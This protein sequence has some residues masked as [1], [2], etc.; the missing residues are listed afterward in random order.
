M[1][2]FVVLNKML[3]D[4]FLFVLLRSNASARRVGVGLEGWNKSAGNRAEPA[5]RTT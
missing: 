4:L 1:L 2:T 3:R 5:V